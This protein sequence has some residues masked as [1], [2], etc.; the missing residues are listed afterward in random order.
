MSLPAWLQS[1]Q[2]SLMEGEGLP[3]VLQ[4]RFRGVA[5]LDG[6]GGGQDRQQPAGASTAV[7]RV[8]R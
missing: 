8:V 4:Q 6:C 1:A 2:A 7:C 3:Q 5:V